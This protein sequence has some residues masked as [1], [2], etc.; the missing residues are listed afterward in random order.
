MMGC[1]PMVSMR[2]WLKASVFRVPLFDMEFRGELGDGASNPLTQVGC[3][4][5]GVLVLQRHAAVL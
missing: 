3:L 2:S 5:L 1:L 4:K